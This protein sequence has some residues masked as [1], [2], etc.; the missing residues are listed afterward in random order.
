MGGPSHS[1]ATAMRCSTLCMHAEVQHL[2]E[3]L[4]PMRR[5]K[6][7]KAPVGR[8]ICAGRPY[9]IDR[10]SENRYKTVT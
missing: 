4:D 6:A 8:H 10:V 1:S 9:E 3:D 2:H 5:A 7:A